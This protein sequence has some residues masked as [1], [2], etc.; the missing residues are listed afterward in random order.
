MVCVGHLSS[1]QYAA[2]PLSLPN[3]TWM[4][5]VKWQHHAELAQSGEQ[6]PYS[7]NSCNPIIYV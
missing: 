4:S 6:L 1:E 5:E 2:A 7:T 3:K